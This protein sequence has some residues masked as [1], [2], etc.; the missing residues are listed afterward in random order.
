LAWLYSKPYITAPIV[1]PTKIQYIDSMVKALEIELT[2]EEIKLL[3]EAY[4]PHN[5]IA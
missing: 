3:E 1:G 4:T 5:V 2:I